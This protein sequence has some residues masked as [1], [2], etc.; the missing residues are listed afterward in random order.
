[1][2]VSRR[3]TGITLKDTGIRDD[4][5][6]EPV[7]GIFSSPAY[8]PR[9][10]DEGANG[11]MSP[12]IG[13]QGESDHGLWRR[14]DQWGA[15]VG[16][17]AGPGSEDDPAAPARA[18]PRLPPARA[19]PFKR[20]QISG[21]P[22]RQSSAKP[23]LRSSAVGKESEA[24]PI[25]SRT[26]PPAN[27]KLEYGV[28]AS[29]EPQSPF[30][31]KR[32]LRRS[33]PGSPGGG[34]AEVAEEARNPFVNGRP[35][36]RGKPAPRQSTGS[37]LREVAIPDA[38]EAQNGEND[39]ADQIGE[40]ADE[41]SVIP[42]DIVFEADMDGGAPVNMDDDDGDDGDYH[43]GEALQYSTSEEI[44]GAL[45]L[46][47]TLLHT[48]SP[49]TA[50]KGR[51]SEL[52]QSGEG[53]DVSSVQRVPPVAEMTSTSA[54]RK[55]DRRTLEKDER[56][57]YEDSALKESTE[58]LAQEPT[59]APSSKRPRKRQPEYDD[60]SSAIFVN[61]ETDENIAIDPALLAH[62]DSYA[63]AEGSALA[64]SPPS[65]AK[66]SQTGPNAASRKPHAPVVRRRGSS[67][68]RS[69][70]TSRSYS[71]SGASRSESTP[72]RTKRAG[73]VS[74]VHLRASTPFEDAGQ[75]TSRAGRPIMKPLKHWAG[76]GVI[77]KHG[78]VDGVIRANAIEPLEKKAKPRRKGKTVRRGGKTGGK[79]AIDGEEGVDDELLPDVWE[80]EI[81]VLSGDV[82]RWDAELGVG[83]H[84][85]LVR[86]GTSSDR[87]CTLL[88][89]R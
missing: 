87:Y 88:R 18:T 68:A 29:I 72:A 86:E 8:T 20:T 71:P 78:E 33:V 65:R 57:A 6:L 53:L 46:A 55:R 10:Q 28:R 21:S 70:S 44:D 84:E 75:R 66:A 32:T 14:R 43:D 81:G 83:S 36:P 41:R 82:G 69:R 54:S 17:Y 58:V 51:R 80:E 50:R 2:A 13:L 62:G 40:D 9:R 11:K 23:Q 67:A 64:Q 89:G 25:Q 60:A 52:R 24:S 49:A 56:H 4:H 48:S 42:P 85:E 34:V 26:Q 76:E 1:M 63:V 47:G 35:S 61:G 27:R 59:S 77:W 79:D 31:P 12:D 45:G 22:R 3:K 74:N 19:S 30:R 16:S 39:S 5:G 15:D 37:R 38:T 7:S 73:T